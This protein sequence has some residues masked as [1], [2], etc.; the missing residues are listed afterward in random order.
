MS[1]RNPQFIQQA[2]P[3]AFSKGFEQGFG[4]QQAKFQADLEERQRLAEEAD[5]ARLG[6]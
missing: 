1:Y 2:D 5:K 6:F 4:E 3:L